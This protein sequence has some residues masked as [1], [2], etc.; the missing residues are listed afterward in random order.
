MALLKPSEERQL[1]AFVKQGDAS[2]CKALFSGRPEY[3]KFSNHRRET[4]LHIA[5]ELGHIE[6]MILLM[7]L[8]F[9]PHVTRFFDSGNIVTPLH[10]A[11]YA[12]K[13]ESARLLIERGADV[14]AGAGIHA[15]PLIEA[16]FKGHLEMVKLLVLYGADV[17]AM[18]ILDAK[19]Y[20]MEVDALKAS[21]IS[22]NE[23][24]KSFLLSLKEG[25]A[26][27]VIP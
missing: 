2:N 20:P 13:L 24:I 19:P 21:E 10:N 4:L 22:G 11:A 26:E 12:G 9:S 3:L 1:L 16:A 17:N 7:D 5:S 14:N 27:D 23:K 15:T 8:G 18:Y 25:R 6:L